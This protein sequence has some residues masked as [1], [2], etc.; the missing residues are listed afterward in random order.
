MKTIL[1]LS[2]S[3]I[4]EVNRTPYQVL[5]KIAFVQVILIVP[6]SWKGD[7]IEN[8]SYHPGKHIERFIVKALPVRI[9]GNGSLFTFK[10]LSHLIKTLPTPDI[11][12][13]DEEPWSLAALQA[14]WVLRKIPIRCFFSKQ[15]ILK[16]YPWPFRQIEKWIYQSSQMAFVIS[17]EVQTVLQTKGFSKSCFRLSHSIDPALFKPLSSKDQANQR[18]KLGILKNIIFLYA[19]RMT[20]EKGIKLLLSVVKKI[21]SQPQF[22]AVGF[23]WI[24]NGP[25]LEEVKQEMKAFPSTSV[26]VLNAVAHNQIGSYLALCDVLILPSQTRPHWKEQFGRILIEAMAS[27]TAVLGSDS[28]EISKIIKETGGGLVFRENSPE[29]LEKQIKFFIQNPEKLKLFKESGYHFILKNFT[30]EAVAH[31]LGH[32]LKIMN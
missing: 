32:D 12:F 30:H 4:L 18:A 26:Q 16:H 27:Q 29:E 21:L 2:H 6:S 22:N 24:G 14:F 13:V 10:G 20:E 7:L 19:G 25:L 9:S 15:N 28:G 5:S 23:L 1:V 3:G 11:L 17:E 31:R 8:L